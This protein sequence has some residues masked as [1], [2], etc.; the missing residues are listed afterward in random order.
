M[1]LSKILNEG[2]Q[3][4]ENIK[5]ALLMAFRAFDM[6]DAML[7][8]TARA[9]AYHINSETLFV[10]W[11]PDRG[12][13]DWFKDRNFK[14][15]HMNEIQKSR[16]FD[17]DAAYRNLDM[18]HE[19]VWGRFGMMRVS[20][21]TLEDAKVQITPELQDICDKGV[22][23][24]CSWAI[25]QCQSYLPHC[26]NALKKFGLPEETVMY[27]AVNAD[28]FGFSPFFIGEEWNA[29][30]K[31]EKFDYSERWR[32]TLGDAVQRYLLSMIQ[33]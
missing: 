7:F 22:P 23:Y 19:C 13:A 4:E 5:A 16:G 29:S 33:D 1:K 11:L 26:A 24:A 10:D 31:K 17:C 25:G 27:A 8:T 30:K 9:F 6:D 15:K 20:Q 2:L 18:E 28:P 21:S 14:Q 32:Q 3:L 12:H